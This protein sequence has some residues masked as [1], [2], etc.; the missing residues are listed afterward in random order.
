M[1]GLVSLY[2]NSPN[3][4][5][6][7]GVQSK[8]FLDLAVRDGLTCAVQSNYGVEGTNTTWQTAFGAI[9]H[10]ARG[11]DVYSNDTIAIHHAHHKKS[12]PN[13]PD[14]LVTL[15][16]Q[17]VFTADLKM[18]IAA[19]TPIDH[20]PIPPKVAAFLQKENVTP[21]AMSRFGQRAMERAGISAEYV[22]HS[23]DP[24]IFKP[25]P[26]INGVPNRDYLGVDKDRFIVMMNAA[27]KGVYPNRKA[28]GEN[29]LAFALFAMDKPDVLLYLHTEP[30]GMAGGINLPDLLE[31]V[32]L[33][34][35][36]VLFADPLE[37]RYG[38]SQE[39]L[40][41]LYSA[42]D[43][44]LA[45]SYGEG[46][47]VPTVEA[48]ACGTRVVASNFA[49][50]AEL[51]SPDGF[52]VD[53]QPLWDAPQ[54]SWFNTPNVQGIVAA[55]QAAYDQGRGEFPETREFVKE[56]EVETVWQEHWVPLLSQLLLP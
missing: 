50:S 37:Y 10:Y 52:L 25:T 56:Y 35:D 19:W 53:G 29:I 9:P 40:A 20:D 23:Y 14:L 47:G 43:V 36:K 4:P 21:V 28:F 26:L 18:P 24:D 3:A 22:P 32:N 11:S 41:G 42:A 54:K 51:V 34:K 5:T 15:Y 33:P 48:Q 27:N 55:L 30:F 39:T 2:S 44:L 46:F 31:A 17:W 45:T 1:Q 49:A 13:L 12:A 6:G 8:M 7:Y 16:D 38:I